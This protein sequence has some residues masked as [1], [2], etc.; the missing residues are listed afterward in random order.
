LSLTP[1][2][3]DRRLVSTDQL[4]PPSPTNKVFSPIRRPS[5]G[6]QTHMNHNDRGTICQNIFFTSTEIFR[7]FKNIFFMNSTNFLSD[8]SLRALPSLTRVSDG[9]VSVDNVTLLLKR[10]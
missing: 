10:D 7:I 9:Y 4:R 2:N 6:V 3:A 8:I 1:K 5:A